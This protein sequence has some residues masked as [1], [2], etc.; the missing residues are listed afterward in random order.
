MVDHGGRGDG[1]EKLHVQGPGGSIFRIYNQKT[2]FS[3]ERSR[4]SVENRILRGRQDYKSDQLGA[5][6][7]DPPR[8]LQHGTPLMKPERLER[9]SEIALPQ[10]T[11]MAEFAENIENRDFGRKEPK[12]VLSAMA[13]TNFNRRDG[14]V[15]NA[16]CASRAD[17]H[18]HVDAVSS[19]RSRI[20]F[21]GLATSRKVSMVSFLLG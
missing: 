8:A 21:P 9:A 20:R 10:R 1:L 14:R 18:S 2:G 3:T 4:D 5:A 12:T 11:K 17:V 16:V 6:N 7:S 13:A 15:V 19:G